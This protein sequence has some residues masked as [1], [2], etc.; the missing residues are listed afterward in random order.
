VSHVVA[1]IDQSTF[2][3]CQDARSAPPGSTVFSSPEEL[4]QVMEIHSMD[5]V[6]GKLLGEVVG[7]SSS[8]EEAARRLWLTLSGAAD[9]VYK[10]DWM[11]IGLYPRDI[12]N[13]KKTNQTG[14]IELVQLTWVRGSSPIIDHFYEKLS[15]RAKLLV[16]LLV[17]DGRTV[18]TN[19]QVDSIIRAREDEVARPSGIYLTLYIYKSE[20]FH[21]RILRKLSYLDFATRPEF[22]GMSLLDREP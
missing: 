20:L 19:E 4:A 7:S 14:R 18:W 2:R 10:I 5:V 6:R 12:F 16:D 9:L 3:V 21:K 1:I 15:R 8:R 22:A 17:K 11:S 13:N